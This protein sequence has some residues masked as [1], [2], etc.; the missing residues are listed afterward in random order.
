MTVTIEILQQQM[1]DAVAAL[2]FETAARRRD[3]ISAMRG[4]ATAAEAEAARFEGLTRQA[5][6]AMG[7]GTSRQRMVPPA[8]R[9]RPAALP[10]TIAIAEARRLVAYDRVDNRLFPFSAAAR[11]QR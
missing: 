1:D 4:G 2:D 5:P 11:R 8:G 7:L 6:S 3:R 10:M 9:H